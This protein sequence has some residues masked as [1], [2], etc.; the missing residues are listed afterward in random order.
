VESDLLHNKII[1][2]AKI[3][4]NEIYKNSMFLHGSE[5]AKKEALNSAKAIEALAPFEQ[6][7]YWNS[8]ISELEKK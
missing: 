7:E 3:K 4:A 6:K 8:V 1:M 5:T 2:K